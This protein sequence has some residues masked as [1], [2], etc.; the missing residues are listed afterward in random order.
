MVLFSG[1]VALLVGTV[2]MADAEGAFFTRL[3]APREFIDAQSGPTAS[4]ASSS[5]HVPRPRM[6]GGFR[7]LDDYFHLL[8]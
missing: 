4:Q 6:D 8:P 1:V 5:L 2:V 7:D 3:R